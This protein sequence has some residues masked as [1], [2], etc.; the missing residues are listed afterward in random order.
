MQAQVK[1]KYSKI[2]Q[3]F[4]HY[5]KDENLFYCIILGLNLSDNE[6]EKSENYSHTILL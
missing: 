3:Y 1:V 5:E 2:W 6:E 4:M